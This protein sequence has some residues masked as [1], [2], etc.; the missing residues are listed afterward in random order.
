LK[1]LIDQNLIR[2]MAHI[3]GGGLTENIPRILPSH[4][5]AC[6]RIGSWP[7]LP[8]FKLLQ[9]IGQIKQAEMLRV[10]NMG[11]G[12]AV[13]VAPEDLATIGRHLKRQRQIYYSIGEIRSGRSQ[14]VY[15]S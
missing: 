6:I 15:E 3:T 9:E 11:V 4:C 10:F 14:V 12:M 8:I 2:G 1:P 5:T 13:I 7:V